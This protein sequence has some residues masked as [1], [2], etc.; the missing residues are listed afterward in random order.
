MSGRNKSRMGHGVISLNTTRRT[1]T[2]GDYFQVGLRRVEAT[3]RLVDT[4]EPLETGCKHTVTAM[5]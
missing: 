3:V 2:K 4:T 5:T 1:P